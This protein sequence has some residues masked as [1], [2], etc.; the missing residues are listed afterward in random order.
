LVF[1]KIEAEL[2]VPVGLSEPALRIDVATA[3]RLVVPRERLALA[4]LEA[5]IAVLVSF[6]ESALRIDVAV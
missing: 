3:R 2:A 5:E 1:A 4:N 6:P